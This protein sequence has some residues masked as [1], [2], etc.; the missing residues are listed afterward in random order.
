M[1]VLRCTVSYKHACSQDGATALLMMTA[2]GRKDT[3]ELLLDRGADLEAKGRVGASNS[4]MLHDGP[5]RVSQ[6]RREP[7]W[8]RGVK[9]SGACRVPAWE[10]LLEG[11]SGRQRRYVDVRCRTSMRARS[12]ALPRFLVLQSEAT[13]KRWSCCW[14]TA[15]TWRPSPP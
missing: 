10:A 9:V 4:A 13:R 14:T 11:L 6:A 5:Q 8:R 1:T 15:L 7:R 3:V 2:R 12:M